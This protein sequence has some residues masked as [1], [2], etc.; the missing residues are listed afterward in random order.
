VGSPDLDAAELVRWLLRAG[1]IERDAV[2]PIPGL[3]EAHAAGWR[4]DWRAAADAW[5]RVGA[6]Y[7]RALELIDSGDV[8][9]RTVDHHVS[10]V[11]AKLGVTTRREAARRARELRDG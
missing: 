5:K 9:T 7:E 2:A 1:L 6:P 3:P 10:A 4:G 8:S 11:L